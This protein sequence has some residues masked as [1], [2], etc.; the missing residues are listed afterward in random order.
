ML[1]QYRAIITSLGALQYTLSDSQKVVKV[2]VVAEE[3]EPTL[4]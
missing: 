2:V 3:E 4:F 1:V